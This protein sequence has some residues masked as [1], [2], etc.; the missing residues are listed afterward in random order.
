MICKLGLALGCAGIRHDGHCKVL[1]DEG[2]TRN[3]ENGSCVFKDIRA[4]QVGIHAPKDL[5]KRNPLKQAKME[6]RANAAAKALVEKTDE[7]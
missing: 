7:A 2:V 6:A 1:F 4:P 3:M 5:K